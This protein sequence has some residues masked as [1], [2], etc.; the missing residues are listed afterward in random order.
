MFVN[1]NYIIHSWCLSA[2]LLHA[3]WWYCAIFK[4][5]HSYWVVER[6]IHAMLKSEVSFSFE[7]FFYW[8]SA[9]LFE[10]H[11]GKNSTHKNETILCRPNI[12]IW[13][14]TFHT[15]Q[16]IYIVKIRKKNQRR[17]KK[18][19]VGSCSLFK[20][21]YL[22]ILVISKGCVLKFSFIFYMKTSKISHK[23][24]EC[25]R[26]VRFECKIF[27]NFGKNWLALPS[28]KNLKNRNPLWE[29]RKEMYILNVKSIFRILLSLFK[30]DK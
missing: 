6:N 3:R 2:I 28:S 21:R 9:A 19:R 29:C 17:F 30:L 23:M 22:Q 4:Y 27:T 8:T 14:C 13:Q 25:L 12:S 1:A 26:N 15:I 7:N 11:I 10:M 18:N 5:L 20:F 16:W 24:I